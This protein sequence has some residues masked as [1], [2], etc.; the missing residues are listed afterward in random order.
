VANQLRT[1][2]P[3]TLPETLKKEIFG[4]I[5]LGLTH[6]WEYFFDLDNPQTQR[7]LPGIP[8]KPTD[9]G[10][11]AFIHAEILKHFY[12][13]AIK[14]EETLNRVAI[15]GKKPWDTATPVAPVLA[16]LGMFPAAPPAAAGN[17]TTIIHQTI[18]Q[19]APPPVPAPI[20]KKHSCTIS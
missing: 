4:A 11:Y 1:V 15:T 2:T 9:R 19:Q 20:P 17:A 3:D 5:L 16:Q 12:T 6:P 13:R 18:I 8:V 10:G 7:M 14:R